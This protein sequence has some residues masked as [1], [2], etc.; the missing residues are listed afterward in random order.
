MNKINDWLARRS[1]L[2]VFVASILLVGA[3]GVLDYQTGPQISFSIFYLVPVCLATWYSCRSCGI[4]TAFA[5]AV[6]W[7]TATWLWHLSYATMWTVYWNAV[8]RLGIFLIVAYL[9]SKSKGLNATLQ[10]RVEQRTSELQSEVQYRRWVESQLRISEESYRQLFENSAHPLWVFN[11]DT[12]KILAASERAVRHYGYSNEEFLTMT[13]KDLRPS[14][15][16]PEYLRQLE[17]WKRSDAFGQ[18]ARLGNRRHV[19]KDDTR[20]AVETSESVVNYQGQQAVLLHARDVTEKHHALA[21][22]SLQSEITR[23]MSEGVALVRTTDQTIVYANPKFE[24][25][26][27]YAP[28]E[29]NGKPVALLSSPSNRKPEETVAEITAEL[30]RT[31]VWSGEIL[32]R[33][34]DGTDFWCMVSISTFDHPEYG[35]VWV[36]IN[37]DITEH[38]RAESALREKD[39]RLRAVVDRAPIIV[40]AI[41][42]DGVITTEEGHGLRA[43]HFTNSEN[44]GRHVSE[45]FP[46]QPELI[47]HFKRTLHGEEVTFTLKHSGQDFDVWYAPQRDEHGSVNG[48][49]GVATNVTERVNLQRQVLEISD[50]EQTRIGQDLHDGLCQHLVSIAFATNTLGKR[51]ESHRAP[52]AEELR[53]IA[54]MLDEA[55]TQSR[56]TARG[57]YPVKLEAEGL[58]A[59]LTE[60]AATTRERHRLDCRFDYQKPVFL[61]S[62]IVAMQLWRIAQEA[63]LNAIR[64]AQASRIIIK[65]TRVEDKVEVCVADDGVGISEPL[66]PGPGMGLPI[67]NYRA[68]TIGGSVRIRRRTGGGTEIIGSVVSPASGPHG[69]STSSAVRA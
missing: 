60:L 50:R 47:E 62:D 22:L 59:A 35:K 39:Q 19:K 26:F 38:K 11:P 1:S 49:V 69:P 8:M 55:I 68:R 18:S 10:S 33:N 31:G 7:F 57:L 67:I 36:C 66:P 34:K 56:I 37:S 52:E 43:V 24:S 9:L 40:F 48:I 2:W 29:L 5:S 16:L 41:N 64:H 32:N 17:E 53:K 28:G 54:A 12:L 45:V 58:A 44:V 20:I 4:V 25:M 42:P 23:N 30:I 61:S 51:L 6:A 46:G 65:L 3:L 13:V 63:V 27:G 14:E 21:T 15:D